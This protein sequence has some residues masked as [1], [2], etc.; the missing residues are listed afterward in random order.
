M[1]KS[2][3]KMVEKMKEAAKYS[4]GEKKREARTAQY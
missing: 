4:Q 3:L 2:A 1:K